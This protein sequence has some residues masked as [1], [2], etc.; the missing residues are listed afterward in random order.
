MTELEIVD[1]HMHVQRNDLHGR[2]IR[3]CF[4]GPALVKPGAPNLGTLPEVRELMAH[5]G[6]S[7]VNMLSFT[8]SGRYF[9]HGQYTLPDDPDERA[10]AERDVRARA[11]SRARG[12]NDW[13]SSVASENHDITYFAGVNPVVL[14][15]EGAVEEVI[16]QR[17]QGA[18][19]VKL[20]PSDM[21]IPGEDRALFPL[22]EFLVQ[23]S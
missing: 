17:A 12:N 9:R 13:A 10:I 6:I 8:W 19:G 7:A 21:G 18:L 15:A 22:Y 5:T 23:E 11:A 3:D 1:M 4:L 16:R 2:E 20:V 14:G